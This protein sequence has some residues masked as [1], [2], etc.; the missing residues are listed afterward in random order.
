VAQIGCCTVGR[1][2][3]V[4]VG[5]IGQL[6]GSLIVVDGCADFGSAKIIKD[7]WPAKS[8]LAVPCNFNKRDASGASHPANR[9]DGSLQPDGKS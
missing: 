6:A 5:D 9:G 7:L 3:I 2:V 4:L 8:D 1:I